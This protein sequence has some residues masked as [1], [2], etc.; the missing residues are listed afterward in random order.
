MTHKFTAIS[1]RANPTCASLSTDNWPISILSSMACIFLGW[2]DLFC[3]LFYFWPFFLDLCLF[4][5]H[6]NQMGMRKLFCQRFLSCKVRR[7]CHFF[8]RLP[9]D[10]IV[11]ILNNHIFFSQQLGLFL[12]YFDLLF[13][14]NSSQILIFQ[15]IS[16]I[17]HLG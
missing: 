15:F 11:L 10:F 9:I 2:I 17:L 13:S 16:Q 14:F 6:L 4:L 12:Q 3:F 8:K 5:S 1:A 7:D